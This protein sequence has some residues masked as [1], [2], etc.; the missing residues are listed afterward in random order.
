MA[1][2]DIGDAEIYVETH[3]DGFPVFL[4][5][6]LGGRS[7]FWKQQVEAFAEHFKVILHDHR[8]VGKSTPDKV[9]FGAEH[10]SD[11]LIA[12]MQAMDIEK[13][14]LVGHS[15]G[16]A[17]GQHIALK[18][19]ELL[20]RLVLSCSWAGPDAYFQHLFQ[21]RRQILIN[22]GPEAYITVGNYLGTPSSFLQPQ[23]TSPRAFMNERMAA[24]PGLQ[25]ELSRLA[26][27][28][29]HD[30]RSDVHKIRCPTLC[31]GAQDDQITPPGFTTELAG[32]IDGA[33]L[34]LLE[35]GG[36]FCPISSAA[37][38]NPA[39]LEFLTS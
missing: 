8:G 14:H 32:L 2:I 13:A 21:T 17:I 34:K 37:V 4:V 23:M 31:I 3:G 9:V 5:A 1:M 25:V 33:E 11:D 7:V 29:G 12:V 27:V 15:T 38:Y 30:L 18:Q 36:H 24:F 28:L 16:G 22:C 26:A 39:V 19:P 10:M 35:H 20:D 6:G